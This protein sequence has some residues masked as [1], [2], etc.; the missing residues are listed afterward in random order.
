[1]VVFLDIDGVI[2]LDWSSQKWDKPCINV[3]NTLTKELN[4]KYVVTSTWRVKY[5]IEELQKIFI[6][7]GI[8]GEII[9]YTPILCQDRGL[10]IL[11]WFKTNPI[12]DWICL[13][14]K[15]TDIK[16]YIDPDRIYE[17]DFIKGLTDK[18]G[19]KILKRFKNN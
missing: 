1:M 13:D 9:D 19:Q 10:E 4:L 8:I 15:I 7:Q 18:I 11:E 2:K 12:H 16:E 6:K 17:C 5:S 3:L 14:D